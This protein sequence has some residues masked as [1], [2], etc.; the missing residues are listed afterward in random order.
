[1]VVRSK[2][3]KLMHRSCK[4]LEILF[5]AVCNMSISIA[6]MLTSILI[7]IDNLYFDKKNVVNKIKPTLITSRTIVKTIAL[8]LEDNKYEK[9]SVSS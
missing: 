4:L 2:Y 3:S 9:I 1:M 8:K 5:A 6:P 7:N